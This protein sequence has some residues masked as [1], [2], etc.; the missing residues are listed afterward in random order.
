EK[1]SKSVVGKRSEPV[2]EDSELFVAGV[3]KPPV[4]AERGD[5]FHWDNGDQSGEV[6]AKDDESGVVDLGK[7]GTVGNPEEDLLEQTQPGVNELVPGFAHRVF[8]DMPLKNM[9]PG[10]SEDKDVRVD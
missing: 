9:D 4:L 6:S 7:A 5:S 8:V 2:E 3:S 1:E 10:M